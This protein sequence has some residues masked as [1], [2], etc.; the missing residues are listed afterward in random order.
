MSDSGA[1]G[2]SSAR[3]ASK[4]SAN[5]VRAWR[6]MKPL[7]LLPALA[8]ALLLL[9]APSPGAALPSTG[10]PGTMRDSASQMT[11]P[12]EKMS[13]ASEYGSPQRISGACGAGRRG[14]WDRECASS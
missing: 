5:L 13:A 4:S 2:G 10:E 14:A 12:N 7:S 11:T 3:S 8:P 9:L 1:S 6:A